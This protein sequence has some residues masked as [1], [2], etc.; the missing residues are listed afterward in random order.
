MPRLA[1]GRPFGELQRF[2]GVIGPRGPGKG[3]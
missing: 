1:S 2:F 3:C